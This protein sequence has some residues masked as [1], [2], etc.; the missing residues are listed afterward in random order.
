MRALVNA[1]GTEGGVELREVPDP[2]PGPGECLVRVE[3]VSLNRGELRLL[4]MRPKGWRPGQDLAGTVVAPAADGTGPPAGARVVGW[5]DQAGWAERAAVST[6]RVAALADGVP[7]EVGATLPIAGLTAL[8][9]LRLA[10]FLFGARTLVTGAAGGV[11]RLTVELA[12]L[13]N[14]AVT[15][16]VGDERRGEG[17]AE[18]GA[19]QVVTDLASAEGPFDVVLESVGGEVLSAALRML[20]PGGTLVSFGNSSGL[21][22]EIAFGSWGG[23]G[24]RVVQFRVYESGEPP[25][26]GDDLALLADLVARDVLHPQVGLVEDWHRAGQALRAL[27]ERRVNGKAVLRVGSG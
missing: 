17:L 27:R 14:A 4:D 21:P 25:A 6:G 11:G 22:S 3:A 26:F 19:A 18:L 12:A 5:V 20:A 13:Q 1:P 7:P 10:P 2:E 16:L 23:G 15:A 9:T 24:A 8:R